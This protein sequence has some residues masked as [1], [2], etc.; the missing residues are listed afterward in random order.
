MDEARLFDEQWS[1]H[2]GKSRMVGMARD[3]WTIFAYWEVDELRRDMIARHFASTWAELPLYLCV[4]DVTGCWF[5]GTNAPLVRQ[6][7][8]SSEA[9]SWYIH[10]MP[11]NRNYVLD[12]AITLS[13][14]RRFSILRSNVVTLP[15]ERATPCQ[16]YVQFLPLVPRRDD[17]KLHP[18]E[19]VFDGYHVHEPKGDSVCLKGI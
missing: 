17:S 1:V 3:P 2:S 7:R 14:E 15:P 4:Y 13:Q 19:A 11:P 6:M 8:V 9:Y 12:L 18:Y 10:D 5:D 16:P